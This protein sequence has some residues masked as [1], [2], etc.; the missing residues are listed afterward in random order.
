[1]LAQ[2][3]QQYIESCRDLQQVLNRVRIKK[4]KKIKTKKFKAIKNYY[5]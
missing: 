3:L 1:M 4:I 5:N 2:F